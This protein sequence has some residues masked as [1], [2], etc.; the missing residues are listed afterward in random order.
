MDKEKKPTTAAA[1]AV[2]PPSRRSR[3]PPN[4]RMIQNFHLMWLDGNIDEINNEDCRNSITK[5]RLVV[6]TVDTFTDA[7]ESM[8]HI[9]DNTGEKIFMIVSQAFSEIIIPIVQD[10]PQVI[11]VYYL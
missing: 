11:S 4:A 9:T 2:E 6:N 10:I 8:D 7:D 5:L 3:Q 1:T